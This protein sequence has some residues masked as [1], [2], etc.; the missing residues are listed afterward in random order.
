MT[1]DELE[2]YLRVILINQKKILEQLSSLESINGSKEKNG[3]DWLE[4]FIGEG[5]SKPQNG[6]RT[7]D[8]AMIERPP[9]VKEKFKVSGSVDKVISNG[10]IK[11]RVGFDD[12]SF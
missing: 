2:K 4:S 3:P 1:S 8:G 9:P 12:V 11:D 7:P 5:K 6:G 10:R